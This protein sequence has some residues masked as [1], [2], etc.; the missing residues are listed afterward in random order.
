MYNSK[1]CIIKKLL[2]LINKI[3]DEKVFTAIMKY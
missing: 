3:Y 2:L 1:I